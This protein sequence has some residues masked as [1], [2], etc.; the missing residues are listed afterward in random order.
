[1]AEERILIR[2]DPDA[3]D[4][5]RELTNDLSRI[6]PQPVEVPVE[7]DTTRAKVTIQKFSTTEQAD[8]IEKP[9]EVDTTRARNMLR[10]FAAQAATPIQ[11]LVDL[12]TTRARAALTGLQSTGVKA[13][14]GIGAA[15]KSAGVGVLLALGG[16]AMQGKDEL[17][18][19][20]KVS[21]QTTSLLKSTGLAA[22]IS[23]GDIENF[24]GAML[25]KSGIDDQA[26]QSGANF[27]L[28]QQAFQKSLKQNPKLLNEAT[29]ALT[30]LASSPAFNGNATAAA[31]A[32]GRALNDPTK[33]SAALRKSGV[34]LTED[35]Q[36]KIKTLMESG[37]TMEAQAIVI[38]KLNTA[39]KGLAEGRGNSIEGQ[40]SKIGE[41]IAGVGASI[42]SVAIPA[43]TKLGS[44]LGA[45]RP[46]GRVIA[47]IGDSFSRAF[48][49]MG[50]GVNIVELISTKME[51][52]A[53]LVEDNQWVVDA[54]A[55]TFAD[56]AKAAGPALVAL[57]R[58]LAPVLKM[59]GVVIA[60]TVVGLAKFVTYVLKIT[61][62]LLNWLPTLTQVG[63]KLGEWINS[64]IVFF[65][66]M[67]AQVVAGLNAFVGF[68]QALPGRIM[69]G[70]RAFAGLVA[71]FFR[72]AW[73]RAVTIGKAILNA[74][75][76][77]LRAV[78]GRV[79]GALAALGGLLYNLAVA[80]FNRFKTAMVNAVT[81]IIGFVKAIPGRIVAALGAVGSLLYD[82][83][84]AVF[85]GF[86]DGLKHV[87]EKIKGWLSGI[88]KKIKSLKGPIE[89]DRVLLVDEGKA[90]MEG[91][92]KGLESKWN[93][94][95][96]WLSKRGGFI[97]GMLSKVGLGEV[98]A[99]IGKLFAG[100]TTVD[101]V[102]G[103]IDK[104]SMDG[105]H[106][107]SGPADTLAMANIIAKRF[108]MVI[109]SFMNHSKYTTTGNVSQHSVGMAADFSN[110]THPT[111]Q[112]DALAAWA[113][114][115]VG[116]AFYQV[117]YRTLVGGNHFNHVH[118][119]W[120]PRK[121]GGQV[122]RGANY[123]V[124]EAGEEWFV[125]N[126]SGFIISNDRLNRLMAMDR[127]I[128]TMEHGMRSGAP[129]AAGAQ[130][131]QEVTINM[132]PNNAVDGQG[133]AMLTV[134]RL[135]PML[136]ANATALAGGI[137]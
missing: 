46:L 131:H 30:G 135:L 76:A 53:K 121:N 34:Q 79:I 127:R 64:V 33:A 134:N 111:P 45:F 57:F 72:A 101:H 69:A 67:A 132:P 32:L 11:K 66:N 115:L 82:K 60:L 26:I 3:S 74:Y 17:L 44:I 42:L 9:V 117:L 128:G 83:G 62:A 4:F 90:I 35:E 8:P 130:V 43:L 94:V 37:K 10:T 65:Q 80:A 39:T 100:E 28:Q 104:H 78:P 31:K 5:Q 59:L 123:R 41:T 29:K 16:A 114:K 87:W 13:M 75:I 119:G 6:T 91:F 106:P 113:Y 92:H 50:E 68:I 19:M 102:L 133:Y 136:R 120:L 52:F 27:L 49:G 97:K 77:Y 125:P 85:E 12:D 98:E 137:S 51:E 126:Q 1:M 118:I 124:G 86:F 14:N 55:Q 103:T 96:G 129:T 116:K 54:F 56:L 47:V 81:N 107:S 108:G 22:K 36:K 93:G 20:N 23:T 122:R 61:T 63:T 48:G 24:A 25:K 15:T 99:D 18:E 88:G 95:E 71:A 105:M 58:Q 7:A 112:M 84:T 89:V 110:G 38:G 40:M 73:N 70:L 2:V 21:A 109:T